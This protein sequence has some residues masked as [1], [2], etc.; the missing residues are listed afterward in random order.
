[1]K[2]NAFKKIGIVFILVLLLTLFL[3]LNKGHIGPYSLVYTEPV[4]ERHLEVEKEKEFLSSV[5]KEKLNITVK[6]DGEEI[7]EGYVLTSSNEEV[8]K[9]TDD[10]EI[11]AVS[12]GK[13]K[14]T[15]EYDIA[16]IEFDVKVITPIKSL[17]FTTTNSVIR[18]GKDLQ[19]KLK[20]TPSGASLDS[21]R[22]ESSDEE[23]ATVN[24]NGIVRGVSEG[25]V[26]ITIIDEYTGT[27]KE[28]NLTVKK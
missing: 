2:N 12:D 25:K 14:I 26:T 8:V 20:T 5:D 28:V 23:I 7:T 22:Y 18:V 10:N 1:M 24:A 11:Q 15:V 21:L 19:L 27:E 16:E 3:V 13:A 4:P 6:M 17:S 9:I